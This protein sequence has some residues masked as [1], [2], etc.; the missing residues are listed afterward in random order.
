[1]SEMSKP[2]NVLR[3]DHYKEIQSTETRP[4]FETLEYLEYRRMWT[5]CPDKHIVPDT[6]INLD[7]HVTNKC[8]LKCPFCPRTWMDLSGSYDDYGFMTWELYKK[9]AD[10]ALA[11]VPGLSFHRGR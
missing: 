3:Q 6:P 4:Y 2:I 8:N 11:R 5:E 9:I 7:I 1:M 10:E